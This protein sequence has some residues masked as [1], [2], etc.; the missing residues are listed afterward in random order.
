MET[1]C[2]RPLDD[3]EAYHELPTD[4]HLGKLP[5]HQ[6]CHGVTIQGECDFSSWAHLTF[7]DRILR[8]PENTVR[9]WRRQS[10]EDGGGPSQEWESQ[11]L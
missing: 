11:G 10:P 8:N 2:N 5:Q 7:W 9:T 4:C 1:I 6:D 3:N